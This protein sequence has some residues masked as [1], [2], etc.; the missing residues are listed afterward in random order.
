MAGKTLRHHALD[1]ILAG[2]TTVSEVMSITSQ[3][4]D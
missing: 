4:E 2:K 1:Q 3:V